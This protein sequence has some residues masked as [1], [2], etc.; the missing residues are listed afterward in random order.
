LVFLLLAAC[1][2]V[3]VALKAQSTPGP[4]L[5]APSPEPPPA[6]P[7]FDKPLPDFPLNLG[8][9]WVYSA[10][11][12]DTYGTERITATYIITETIVATQTR[13]PYFAAELVRDTR[14]ITFSDYLAGKEWEAYYLAGRGETISFWYVLSGTR[15]YQQ[16]ELDWP[17]IEAGEASLEYIFPLSADLLWYPDPQQRAE[18]LNFELLPGLRAVSGPVEREVPAGR[19]Q[20]CFEIVTYFNGGSPVSWFCPGIG[21]VESQYHHVGTP[22]GNTTVLIYYRHT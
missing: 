19:F 12:Y 3:E 6:L 7:L 10:T 9:T 16:N 1:D 20:D 4:A 18:F 22:F 14:I 11:H 15:V 13:P 17:K 21:V 8:A 2:P 5:A